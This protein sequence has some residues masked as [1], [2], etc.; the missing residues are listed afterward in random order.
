MKL[1]NKKI[2]TLI[3]LLIILVMVFTLSN[4]YGR[5]KI[6]M[7]TPYKYIISNNLSKKEMVSEI[8]NIDNKSLFEK[9]YEEKFTN[10]YGEELVKVSIDNVN[11]AQFNN[12]GELIGFDKDFTSDYKDIREENVFSKNK[13]NLESFVNDEYI[14]NETEDI[15]LE[16]LEGKL[17]IS[18]SYILTL[19]REDGL[20]W[21]LKYEKLLADGIT[22]PHDSYCI[23]IDRKTGELNGYRRFK[24]EIKE[25]NPIDDNPSN[26][27][28]LSDEEKD[29][30]EILVIKSLEGCEE[31]PANYIRPVINKVIDG[32]NLYVDINGYIYGELITELYAK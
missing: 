20:I 13:I 3:S 25:F 10:Y 28:D 8:F 18:S 16:K 14:I 31:Y 24:E 12:K 30:Y 26:Y 9:I 27:I 11:C 15:N 22:N 29:N 4:A 17:D 19:S 32:K 1:N 5:E 6:N 2:K 7:D 21:N 23:G